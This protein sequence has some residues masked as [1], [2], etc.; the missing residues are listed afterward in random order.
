MINMIRAD[1]YRLVR[2]KGFY[3][4]LLILSL[5]IG[6]SIYMV[7]PGNVGLT[8]SVGDPEMENTPSMQNELANMSYEE[9]QTLSASD[10]REIMLKTKGYELDRDM[11]ATNIN[12]Y[13]IFIFFAVII[14]TA[15][16]SGSSIK[17]TLSSA[18][19]KKK[20][21]VSKLMLI[22][23]CC[24]I[25][26]F[27]NTY[28]SYFTNVVFNGK[29]LASS[30]ETVTKI[31]LLQLPSMLALASILTGIGFM[32][33]RTALFNTITIPLILV[34]QMVLNL[35]ASIFKIKDE[36]L[37][38]EFQVM[39]GKLANNPSDGFISHSFLV[40]IAVIIVLNLLGYL[41]FKKA[42]IR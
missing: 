4:A 8:V 16:F 2:S 34:F 20:Y 17:N 3:I 27:L 9:I 7:Q 41:S 39:I 12:L 30:L 36:Y 28:I 33:K 15:D 13:Y 40:C 19:S 29:N 32:V 26:F 6:V 37:H 22:S 42:E 25:V 18:I 21:Y 10:F 23:L 5:M 11:L 38:Y 1:F 35:A 31:S 14:L 24:I